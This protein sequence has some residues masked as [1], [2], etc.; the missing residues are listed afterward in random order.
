MDLQVKLPVI[1][2]MD[3]K[4][5]VDLVNN[6]SVGGRTRHHTET[7][8]YYLCKLKEQG[9]IVVKWTPGSGK[10]SDLFT[11]NL[12]RKDFNKHAAVDFGKDLY[13]GES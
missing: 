12:Q 8:Q 2:E 9:K 6:Y 5:A 3:N 4:Q 1:L 10:S 7:R 13:M 11:K